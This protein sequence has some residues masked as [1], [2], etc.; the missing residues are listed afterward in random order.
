MEASDPITRFFAYISGHD[1]TY[2][3]TMDHPTMSA[4]FRWLDGESQ[5]EFRII[6]DDND[7]VSL[8]R[9]Q[10]GQDQGYLAHNVQPSSA[11]QALDHRLNEIDGVNFNGDVA[12]AAF[13]AALARSLNQDWVTD[14]ERALGVTLVAPDEV[15]V[16][17]D[18][19]PLA[20]IQAHNGSDTGVNVRVSDDRID[21]GHF[22]EPTTGTFDVPD[23]AAKMVWGFVSL[24]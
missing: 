24:L 7:H 23:D 13:V 19:Y 18:G 2:T 9:F 21:N 10:G 3:L 5:P 11:A 22:L 12:T 1:R 16:S 17:E 4:K 14:T 20:R 15:A 6:Q 8:V